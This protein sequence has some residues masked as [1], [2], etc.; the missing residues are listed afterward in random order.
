M[1]DGEGFE[2][3]IPFQVCRFSRPEPSTARPPIRRTQRNYTERRFHGGCFHFAPFSDWVTNRFTFSFKFPSRC[4][5]NNRI[6]DY[7]SG[8]EN[9]CARKGTGGSNPSLSA[10]IPPKFFISL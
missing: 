10:M 5:G 1:A 7:S 8:L 3:P 2:P 6:P 4:N 9:R